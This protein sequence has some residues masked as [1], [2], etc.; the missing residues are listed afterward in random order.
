MKRVREASSEYNPL[1]GK[2]LQYSDPNRGHADLYRI[3]FTNSPLPAWICDANSDEIKAVNDAAIR[4]FGYSE[5]EL[6]QTGMAAVC[7]ASGEQTTGG[8]VR[9]SY[10]R[11]NGSRLIA[12]TRSHA[13]EFQG[14][15]SYLHL[16]ENISQIPT[17]TRDMQSLASTLA[18]ASVAVLVTGAAVGAAGPYIV[19]ANQGFSQL[20]GYTAAETIGQPVAFFQTPQ[21]E[22]VSPGQMEKDLAAFG[23]FTYQLSAMDRGGMKYSAE[24]HVTPIRDECGN[25]THYLNLQR[26][27]TERN[28]L[29]DQLR[30]AE[31]ME[32]VGRL[33]GGIAHD[34]NNLLTIILGYSGLLAIE[35]KN[36]KTRDYGSRN[37]G[38]IQKAAEK[39]AVLTSQLL[40]FSRKQVFRP[41]VIGLNP[42]ITN[43]EGMLR[44]LIG[45]DVD[46]HFVLEPEL[47]TVF[48]DAGQVEQVLMN[49]AVNAR[50]AMPRGGTLVIE[51]R[52][53]EITN[54]QA[55][56]SAIEAGRYVLLTIT[57]N[58][59]GMDDATRARA[60]EPFFTTKESGRGTGLGLS[61]TFGFVKKSGGTIKIYSELGHG[62]CFKIYLPRADS[63]AVQEQ[64]A[65][66]VEAPRGTG[67]ILVV[68]DDIAIRELV[69]QM[70][71]G[72]GY[73][74]L[75]AANRTE[76]IELARR[77]PVPLD[78]LLTDVVLPGASGPD[79][80]AELRE[81][82]PGLRVLFASG[83]S[84]HALVCQGVL[85]HGDSFV[86]KPFNVS[87][88][89]RIVSEMLSSRTMRVSAG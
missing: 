61:M 62:A 11:K 5:Q 53:V 4:E 35:M 44:R 68:E 83:Y 37:L 75:V 18:D 12:Q 56:A 49:L 23:S 48:T 22:C 80:A 33:A 15:P 2:G 20:T 38:E 43:V 85:G 19:F 78:L 73:N 3:L 28:R 77:A 82:Q 45:E 64:A 10:T 55:P 89:L 32:A 1:S 84:D 81:L 59:V 14:R 67:L 39:A 36:P 76:A 13:F 58:G 7:P 88:L 66:S 9:N 27:V 60:F 74:A 34:F 16:L 41:N 71:A 47:G 25:I 86:Q 69:H 65:V 40:A 8:V 52:N 54:Q 63:K 46:L 50:D 24:C 87:E 79:L 26:D 72:A 30:Q 31:K 29:Q 6:I 21:D 42:I 51:T 17:V 57:D 70:L